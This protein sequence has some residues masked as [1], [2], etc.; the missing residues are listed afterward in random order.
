MTSSTLPT[1][2]PFNRTGLPATRPDAESN[3][4][5][6]GNFLLNSLARCPTMKMPIMTAKSAIRTTMPTRKRLPT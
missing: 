2:T 5:S 1:V 4:V 6:Y 3:R